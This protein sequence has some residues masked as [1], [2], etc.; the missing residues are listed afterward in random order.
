MP[1]ILV[2]AA[3]TIWLDPAVQDA[4]VLTRLLTPYAGEM[5]ACEV[6]TA[7]NSVR[8]D[9]PKLTSLVL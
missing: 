8:N 4:E 7:V 9:G 1:V 3:E 5:Q 2:P 6:R